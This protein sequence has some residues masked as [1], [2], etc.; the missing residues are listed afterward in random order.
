MFIGRHN[1]SKRW[2]E[3]ENVTEK[4]SNDIRCY[5]EVEWKR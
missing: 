2:R 3:N 4:D 1:D 5:T